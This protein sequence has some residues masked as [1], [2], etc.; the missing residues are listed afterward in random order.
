MWFG[1][2]VLKIRWPR[3][4]KLEKDKRC[5]I[6]DRIGRDNNGLRFVENWYRYPNT[7]EEISEYQDLERML[8]ICKLS[9]S[10]DSWSWGSEAKERFTVARCKQLLAEDNN[11]YAD[12]KFKWEAW[13][14][15]KVN[16]CA[17]RAS[18]DR[19][20][21]REALLQRR[22]NIPDSDCPMCNCSVE[23]LNHC[24]VGCG[25]A[26]SVWCG[27]IKWCRL[28]PFFAYEY[29]DLIMLY[30][31]MHGGKWRKKIIRGIVLIGSWA[32]WNARNAKVFQ[33]KEVKVMEVVAEVKSKAFLW[34]KN[35]SKFN[36]IVWKDWATYP[37]YMCM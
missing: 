30:K 3:L 19:L 25:F 16:I 6:M 24:F 32:L 34:L 28:D 10:D 2:T 12:V 9:D 37:L 13:V 31:N 29:E 26:Y 20:P 4:Y 14:P 33:H 22:F 21:T 7:V 36:S 11:G 23:D 27:I 15:L 1:E 17:W 18:L 8:L 35:R 5:R